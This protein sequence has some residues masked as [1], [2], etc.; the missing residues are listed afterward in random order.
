MIPNSTTGK[1]FL[2]PTYWCV[3]S[4]KYSMQIESR[5]QEFLIRW[6]ISNL[7]SD[8]L[9]FPSF[10]DD[11]CIEKVGTQQRR[12]KLLERIE[13]KPRSICAYQGVSCGERSVSDVQAVQQ[14][15]TCT[16]IHL[17]RVFSARAPI[18]TAVTLWRGTFCRR[19][20]KFF[21][22]VDYT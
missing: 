17:Q 7:Q 21:V 13:T 3:E 20:W 1:H 18:Q 9:C 5:G 11:F 6:P 10:G 12:R 16:R 22:K 19:F 8:L 15:S 4:R 2:S 14:G